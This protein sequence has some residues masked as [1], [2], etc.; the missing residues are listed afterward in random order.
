MTGV[1]PAEEDRVWT[2]GL[3]RISPKI[4]PTVY[5]A[6]PHGVLK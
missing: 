3:A 4:L 6:S 1:K 5:C 2:L